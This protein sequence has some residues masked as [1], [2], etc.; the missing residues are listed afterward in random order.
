MSTLTPREA[1]LAEIRKHI[2]D[3]RE[4]AAECR[5]R[6]DAHLAEADAAEELARRWEVVHDA[7][8][9]GVV[10]NLDGCMCPKIDEPPW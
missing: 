2:A 9:F 5:R 4:D 10:P 7:V 1:Q 8:R 6:A 3:R